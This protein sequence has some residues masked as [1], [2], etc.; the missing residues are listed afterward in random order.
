MDKALGY[1]RVS[2]PEQARE[3]VSLDAQE[4]RIHAYCR[5]SS[6]NLVN[7]V[8][9]DGI[10]AAK[11]LASRPGGQEIVAAVAGKRIGH[12]VA[13]KLDR[14]F[15]DAVDALNQTRTWDRAGIALHLVDIGG[16]TLNT[17]TAI[18]RMFLTMTAAFAELERNL[19]AERTQA[20]L[21]FK[22]SKRQVYGAVPYGYSRYDDALRVIEME[23][24]IVRKIQD[25]HA[26]GWSL[27]KIA[28]TL[29]KRRIQTK[30]RRR[31]H[32]STLRYI[33]RNE[34]YDHRVARKKL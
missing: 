4:E 17:S 14:L 34:L 9:E 3:G 27:R 7:V 18:G 26:R 5:M 13:L 22:K 21:L 15:R 30:H 19:I 29:N 1:V 32:A 8:R 23:F 12:V 31:W 33:L 2:T 16:Q 24:D 11:A 20:A 10:S 28:D 6:L 25:W